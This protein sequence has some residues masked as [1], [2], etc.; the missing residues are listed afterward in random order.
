MSI[1]V[2]ELPP[3]RHT[4]EA[5]TPHGRF[6]RWASDEPAPENIPSGVRHSS[7]MPGG[8]ESMDAVLPRKPGVDYPDLERLTTLR[9]RDA[10]GESV[11]EYRLERA[12][13]T[14][15]DQMAVSPSAVGWQ[16]ALEDDKSA[17]LIVIDRR[18]D[19]WGETG[20]PRQ[21][22]V[23]IPAY[24]PNGGPENAPDPNDG[25]PALKLSIDGPITGSGGAHAEAMFDAG[26]GNLVGAVQFTTE[27]TNVTTDSDWSTFLASSTNAAT[28]AA[29]TTDTDGATSTVASQSLAAARRYLHYIFRWAGGPDA[30]DVARAFWLSDLAVMGDHALTPVGAAPDIGFVAS[31]VLRYAVPL[32]APILRVTDDSIQS[33]DFPIEQLTWPDPTTVGQMVRDA[34][35][36]GLQDWAVWDGPTFYWYDRGTRGRKWRARIGPAQL[37]E[38]GP[39]L[40]RLWNSVV[41]AYQ[42]VDGSTRTVGPPGSGAG[43]ESGL[44]EDPDPQNPATLKGI[45]RRER[46][47]MGVGTAAGA[48]EVGRRF[49]EEQKL[50]DRSGRATLIGHVEDDRGV[51]HPFT[52]VK[53]GD[54]I[55]FVDASDSSYRRVIRP[56]HDHGRRAC[57][58]DL[59]APPEGLTALLERLGVALAPL[60]R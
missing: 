34:T 15:G 3:L 58:V 33:S 57:T 37:E 26:P 56:D 8:Y 12:P 19:G 11:G 49:L 40:E 1:S 54:Q 31:D 24:Q 52:H 23:I 20:R 50:L 28:L 13:R 60:G 48:V 36:F 30:A 6:S 32:F 17:Q 25:S 38:T 9:V 29:E 7:T 2:R 14:S 53:A 16:A 55:S 21:A 51:L 22:T 4:V 18:M 42:D 39:Q 44:L 5:E 27:R 45:V 41:V 59:D 35:R 46:L 43:V 10:A 47:T